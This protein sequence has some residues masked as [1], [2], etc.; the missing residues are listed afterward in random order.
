MNKTDKANKIL[1]TT[2]NTISSFKRIYENDKKLSENEKSDLLRAVLL[3]SCSG[4]DAVMKQLIR[5][6]LGNII[7]VDEG[8][9]SNFKDFIEKKI[10]NGDEKSNSKILAEI[11]TRDIKPKETLIEILKNEL[12]SNSLQSAEEL[13]RVASFFN[14][15]TMNINEIKEVFFARN[16]ITHEM[17]VI[18]DEDELNRRQ[19]SEKNI[20]KLSNT[21]IKVAEHYINSI[22]EKL[23]NE[24]S[25]NYLF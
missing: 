15:E 22:N 11:F 13:A 16:Q 4:V 7:D 10:K 2:K 8:A 3:F 14:I 24:K 9:Y 21:I 19:R 6:T 23:S 5:D 17:D 12:T 18:M 20:I 1:L 25:K